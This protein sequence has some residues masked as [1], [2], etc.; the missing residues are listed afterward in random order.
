M[1]SGREGE[2]KE[3]RRG[4]TYGLARVRPPAVGEEAVAVRGL[5]VGRL[6][7]RAPGQLREGHAVGRDALRLHLEAAFLGH[8]RVPNVVGGEER[9][10]ERHV[11][12]RREAV[13]GRVVGGHVDDGVDVGLWKNQRLLEMGG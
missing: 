2:K 9:R 6:L 4:G 3:K 12:G 5:D 10:V 8:G 13:L 7:E 1:I 11:G